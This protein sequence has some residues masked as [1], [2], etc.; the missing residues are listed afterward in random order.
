MKKSPKDI[1]R[2]T[3]KTKEAAADVIIGLIGDPDGRTKARLKRASNQQL[4]DLH[5]AAIE[6]QKRFQSRGGLERKILDIKFPKGNAD[7]V[8]KQKLSAYG[9]KRLLD[10]HRQL[11]SKQAG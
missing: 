7:E 10:M 4:L 6:M 1:V 11:T 3:W 5:A 8:Y 9:V 2:G